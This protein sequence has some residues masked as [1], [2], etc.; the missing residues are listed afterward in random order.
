[1]K[2]NAGLPHNVPQAE[3]ITMGPAGTLYI[4]SEPNFFYV[5]KRKK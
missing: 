2:G 4:C 1:V 5:F 3:G